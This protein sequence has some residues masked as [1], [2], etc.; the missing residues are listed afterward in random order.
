MKVRARDNDTLFERYTT[1][2]SQCLLRNIYWLRDAT[3]PPR[4][5][6]CKSKQWITRRRLQAQT[7][8]A[9]YPPVSTDVEVRRVRHQQQQC[10]SNSDN[11]S[12]KRPPRR[13]PPL[14]LSLFLTLGTSTTHHRNPSSNYTRPPRR[15][16]GEV[17]TVC[18]GARGRGGGG[19]SE[20]SPSLTNTQR[21]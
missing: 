15:E 19:W 17:P 9:L 10:I 4:D 11:L 6:Y 20:H 18:E 7:F 16:P 21:T 2:P 13:P 1:H 3:R 14:S 8:F 5:V 12:Y